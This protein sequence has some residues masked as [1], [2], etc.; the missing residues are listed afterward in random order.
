MS[1]SSSRNTSVLGIAIFLGLMIP[2]YVNKNADPFNTGNFSLLNIH[3]YT[4][5]IV[6]EHLMCTRVNFGLNFF[7]NLNLF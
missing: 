7:Y 5:T 4:W 6:R 1:L 3:V 2:M